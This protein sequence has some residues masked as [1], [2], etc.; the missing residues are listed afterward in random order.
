MMLDKDIV[1][2]L[3]VLDDSNED[4]T[5][6]SPDEEE[7]MMHFGDSMITKIC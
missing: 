7:D 5:Y 4:P 2:A 3:V 6:L 1:C